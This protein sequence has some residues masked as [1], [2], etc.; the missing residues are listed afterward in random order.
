MQSME[1]T[2]CLS[3]ASFPKSTCQLVKSLKSNIHF[4]PLEKMIPPTSFTNLGHSFNTSISCS[5]SLNPIG[6]Q[7]Q[8]NPNQNFWIYVCPSANEYCLRTIYA[9]TAST[10]MFL[11]IPSCHFNR[12]LR[13]GKSKFFNGRAFHPTTTHQERERHICFVPWVHF[14]FSLYYWALF[15]LSSWSA[16]SCFSIKLLAASGI[17][18]AAVLFCL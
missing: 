1:S 6:L 11:S 7:F 17:Q 3:S 13:F 15:W 9:G 12:G 10:S 18:I 8:F 14:D 16:R 4:N 5:Y 2:R